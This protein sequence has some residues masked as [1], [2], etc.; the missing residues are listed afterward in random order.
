MRGDGVGIG[1]VGGVQGGAGDSK[2]A[3]GS[4]H[5]WAEIGERD[6]SVVV[7]RSICQWHSRCQPCGCSGYV[8]H[9]PRWEYWMGGVH[10]ARAGWADGM[11]GDGLG[12]GLVG[13]VQSRAGDIGDAAGGGDCWAEDREHIGGVV[14]QR[15]VCQWNP[16]YQRC[17][18][19][20]CVDDSTCGQYW[21]G[22][23]H[24]ARSG[25]ADGMRGDRVGIGHVDEV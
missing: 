22:R 19:R 3:T 24:S 15:F 12:I 10:G 4:C 7:Q 2:D 17:G 6:G 21:A 13:E 18:F 23:I 20:S 11:R 1:H 8:K 25:W 5:G 14:F 9:C 16:W